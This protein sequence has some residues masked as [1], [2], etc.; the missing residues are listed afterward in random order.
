MYQSS[1][2]ISL[3]YSSSLRS[4]FFNVFVLAAAENVTDAGRAAV[5]VDTAERNDWWLPRGLSYGAVGSI[6]CGSV[7]AAVICRLVPWNVRAQC[8]SELVITI[9]QQCSVAA[10]VNFG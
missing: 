10:V 4:R 5:G 9:R 6:L 8:L 3:R 2:I 7:D 1:V